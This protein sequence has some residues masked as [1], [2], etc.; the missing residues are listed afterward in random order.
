MIN[1]ALT[2]IR[3]H[4]LRAALTILG[5]AIAITTVV[6]V[7]ALLEGV[8]DLIRSAL[9]DDTGASRI[10]IRF[11]QIDH[12]GESRTSRREN[13]LTPADAA[14][15][16]NAW[17][18]DVQAISTHASMSGALQREGHAFEVVIAAAQPPYLDI[19]RREILA[20]RNITPDD[21][22]TGATVG[23]L[24]A[25]AAKRVFGD[26][27]P[28]GQEFR[29]DGV[30]FVVI[31]IATNADPLGRILDVTI[32]LSTCAAR[33]PDCASMDREISLRV[34]A[35][36][37]LKRI[38]ESVRTRLAE[39]HPD[40]TASDFAVRT[41]EESLQR[42][43]RTMLFVKGVF[44]IICALCLLLGG[45]GLMNVL[46]SSVAERA[47][48][49]GIRR[50]VGARR[51]DI[52]L[53]FLIESLTLSTAGCVVG[54]IL[55]YGLSVAVGVAVDVVARRAGWTLQFEPAVNAVVLSIA[56]LTSTA[57]GLVFGAYPARL[58]ALRDP[59][60][61]LRTE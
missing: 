12:G 5:I 47:R 48:E 36:A 29:L 11:E 15:L 58:A 17:R 18:R 56:V 20:G 41:A 37:N 27:T 38:A 35:N 2:E 53:Q 55:G 54:S 3:N 19:F 42:Q 14:A 45:I 57:V 30:R 34:G 6:T 60:D 9:Y 24:S 51:R 44:A 16:E 46:L 21:D 52:F 10:S 26:P 32:P 33:L 28:I 13:P 49:V 31:G 8:A 40:Y 43:Q 61:A 50:A 39:R 1:A 22:A 7:A 59:A 23:V 25:A 4:P